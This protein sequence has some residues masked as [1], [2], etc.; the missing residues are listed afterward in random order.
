MG[1]IGTD[2]GSD[3]M[4]DIFCYFGSYGAYLLEIAA[5]LGPQSVGANSCLIWDPFLDQD[6]SGEKK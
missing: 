6:F 4:L 1:H 3:W 2:L 5:G